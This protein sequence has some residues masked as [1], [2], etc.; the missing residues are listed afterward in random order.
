[1]IE[2]LRLGAQTE[3]SG[4]DLDWTTA[5][6]LLS[7]SKRCALL[8]ALSR[9]DESLP[10]ADAAEEVARLNSDAPSADIDQGQVRQ[11]SISL[12]HRHVPVLAD[13][14]FVAVEDDETLCL[15]EKG[16][17]LHEIREQ[18]ERENLDFS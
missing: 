16:E 12:H 13:G 1:M 10:L 9:A 11:Y 6:R 18:L 15:T 7:D 4:N 14:G 5:Y 2:D 17:Q 3:A 8:D